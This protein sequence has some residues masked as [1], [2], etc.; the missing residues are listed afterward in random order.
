MIEEL[1]LILVF[2]VITM[3]FY[4]M[5]AKTL[6]MLSAVFGLLINLLSLGAGIPFTPFVQ[7]FFS[8]AELL[9]LIYARKMYL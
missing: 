7:A 3:V 4:K 5:Q 6:V 1:I 8:I 2:F 9:L